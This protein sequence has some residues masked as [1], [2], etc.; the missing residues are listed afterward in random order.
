M[1][2]W[3]ISGSWD[4]SWGVEGQI[5]TGI[6]LVPITESFAPSLLLFWPAA[7]SRGGFTSPIAAN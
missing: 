6:H 7:V 3:T 4:Q 1:A 2:S 5:L